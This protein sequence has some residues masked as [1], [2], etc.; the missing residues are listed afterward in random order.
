[1]PKIFIRQ[2]SIARRIGADS[3]AYNLVQKARNIAQKHTYTT[4][5]LWIDLYISSS[6]T[7]IVQDKVLLAR[8]ELELAKATFDSLPSGDPVELSLI[9]LNYGSIDDRE[10]KFDQAIQAYQRALDLLPASVVGQHPQASLIH[11]NLA[12][13]Y[14]RLQNFDLAFYHAKKSLQIE[15]KVSPEGSISRVDAYNLLGFLFGE[16]GQFDSAE[17]YITYALEELFPDV[18][19]QK[20]LSQLADPTYFRLTDIRT[21]LTCFTKLGEAR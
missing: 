12:L 10:K 17:V 7:Y 6:N 11:S 9:Y 16:I 14:Q 8:Q 21:I 19:M 2:S 3:K 4:K 15:E 20:D 1:Y 18:D 5:E 13:T